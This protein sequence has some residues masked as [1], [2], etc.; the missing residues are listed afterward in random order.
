M[1]DRGDDRERAL[2]ALN[3]A[4][5]EATGY[6][7]GV[8]PE[9]AGGYQTAREVLC[10]FVF[11]HREYVAITR[12]M[13][14]GCRPPLKN[15]TYDQLNDEAVR[16]FAGQEMADLARFLLALQQTL[17]AQLRGLPDW[18]VDFPVKDGGRPKSVADRVPAIESHVRDHIR[19]L[20]RAERLGE[21]WVKAYYPNQDR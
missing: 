9:M 15:G 14:D 6:L 21:A 8:D 12:A 5:V 7:R 10:H 16:E 18:S 3:E 4:L 11:W 19:Q 20:R 2:C 17:L 1:P 13:L